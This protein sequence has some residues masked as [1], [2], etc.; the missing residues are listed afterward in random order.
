MRRTRTTIRDVAE[1]AGVSISTVSHTFSGARP[2]SE[3]TKKRVEE[4]AEALGYEP[5]PSARSLRTGRSGLIGLMLRP[6]HALDGPADVAETF[7][8]LLGSVTTEMLRRK[9]AVVYVPDLDSPI[10]GTVPMDACIVA[11]PYAND[12][13]I[14]ALLRNGM[15]IVLIDE[16]PVRE[17]GPWVVRVDYRAATG[18]LLDHLFEIGMTSA[19][20]ISGAAENAWNLVSREAFTSWCQQQGIDGEVKIVEENLEPS[21]ISRIAHGVL[22][23]SPRPRAVIVAMS[24]YAAIFAAAARQAN[25]RIPED[26]MLASLMDT[27][28]TRQSS[29]P[30]TA[31]DLRHEEVAAAAVDL[32]FRLLDGEKPPAAPLSFA[33][34]LLLRESTASPSPRRRDQRY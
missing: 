23:R 9:A 32:A 22:G 25:V 21:A 19:L 24:D 17:S 29:P 1:R 6:Q 18:A 11:H 12:E 33:P 8:R 34:H 15:P 4:A 31:L 10:I 27:E 14:T 7:N 28:H 26:V 20:L 2:I 5:N 3:A 16:D 30:I 13:A